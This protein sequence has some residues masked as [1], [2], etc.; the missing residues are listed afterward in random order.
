MPHVSMEYSAN[1]ENRVDM[2]A[3]CKVAKRAMMATGLFEL[4][5]VRVRAIRC[6]N[7]AIADEMMKNAFLAVLVRIG[8]GRTMDEKTRLGEALNAALIDAFASL[9]ETPHFALSIDLF[10]NDPA[11]SWKRNT[12]H[13][14][15]RK[16]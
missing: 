8:A 15:L 1:L 11:L 3:I 5:A 16:A 10:E 4:G 6:E 7:Y 14:R 12:I 9:L 2:T 13:A